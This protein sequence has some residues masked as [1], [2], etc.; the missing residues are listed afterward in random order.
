MGNLIKGAITIGVLFFAVIIAYGL[1]ITAPAPERVTPKEMSTSIRV[2]EVEKSSVRLEVTSQGTVVPHKESELIPEV[3]G[4]VSWVSPNLVAGGY[5]NKDEILLKIDNRDYR[6]KVARAQAT[7]SRASAEEELARFELGR[8]EELVKKKLTSQSSLENVLRNHRI[9][10]ASLLDATI[11]LE[12]A[13]RDLWRTEI[14]APY[15]GLVRAEKVDLGQYLS[16]GQSIASIYAGDSAE[17]R[18][19]V[20]DRQLAYLDLPLG[21]RGELSDDLAPE[22][23]L[24]TDYGGHHYEWIGKLVRTEAEIDS[25][26]RMVTAVVRVTNNEDPEQPDLP[27]GLFVNASIKGRAV[28]GVVTL[29]RAALRNQSQVL[30]VDRDNRLHYRAVDVMRF[31]NDSVLISGG[32]ESGDIVNVSPLQTVVEGMRVNAIR[33]STIR[34]ATNG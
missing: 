17:V 22:V 20:A 7:L 24:S 3:N 19:P 25:R 16:R 1:V 2:I 8:M 28:D 9:T 27:V 11:A 26:S 31:E 30:I 21:H 6:S 14:R 33:Q 13:Q 15:D 5:F 32:L 18:L 29:P 10:E 12:Q 34:Q 4:R 23:V